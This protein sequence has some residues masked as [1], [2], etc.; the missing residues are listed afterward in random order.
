MIRKKLLHHELLDAGVQEPRSAFTHVDKDGSGT[1]DMQD[2]WARG[3]FAMADVRMTAS[4]VLE[5]IER[6]R[7]DEKCISVEFFTGSGFQ[8]FFRCRGTSGLF[9]EP[10]ADQPTERRAS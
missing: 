4:T 7:Q 8:A 6:N 5:C 3:S 1:V 9:A 2:S 10:W